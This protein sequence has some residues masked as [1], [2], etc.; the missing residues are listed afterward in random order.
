MA[1]GKPTV[2]S[3]VFKFLLHPMC[4]I[5]VLLLTPCLDLWLPAKLT[6]KI[7]FPF[8]LLPSH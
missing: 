5:Q 4:V 6:S 2:C 3:M 1:A 7:S 8:L